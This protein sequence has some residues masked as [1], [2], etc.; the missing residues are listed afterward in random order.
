MAA[1]Q[2]KPPAPA[3]PHC[4]GCKTTRK[5]KVT[6]LP[7]GV[8]IPYV[9]LTSGEERSGRM[10]GPDQKQPRSRLLYILTGRK[11]CHAL[12]TYRLKN[13]D[14]EKGYYP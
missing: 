14:C 1:R 3:L 10:P 2:E 12:K 6:T 8:S 9:T 11:M 4:V 7:Y 5:F 13:R